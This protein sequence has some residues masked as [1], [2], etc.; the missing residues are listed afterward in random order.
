M[1]PLGTVLFPGALLPLQVFEPRYRELVRRCLDDDTEPEFGVVLIARGMEVGGG[2][3]R[4]DVG[5][6]ARIVQLAELEG[7]RYAL[8]AVGTRRI[9][10]TRWLPDAPYP[11]AEVE[12]WDDEVPAGDGEEAYEQQSLTVARLRR[13][14]ALA[15]EA[16]EQVASATTEVSVDPVL[17]SYHTAS[18]APLGPADAHRLLCA[19]GAV[20]RFVLLRDL[21][22]DVDAALEFRLG[23][24]GAPDPE[25]L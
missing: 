22:D 15:A 18:L 5:T 21:L 3:V 20:A 1:F 24:A 11:L 12:D 8:V 6:V 13:T 23:S 10:V 25:S 19:P 14:L 16:G 2:D 17:A 7:G 9:R 4:T